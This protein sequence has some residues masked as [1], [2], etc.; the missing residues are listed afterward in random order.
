M[1]IP[2][3]YSKAVLM[4]ITNSYPKPV[5]IKSKKMILSM[6]SMYFAYDASNYIF[7]DQTTGVIWS[8]LRILFLHFS[9]TCYLVPIICLV[10]LVVQTNFIFVQLALLWY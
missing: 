5:T 7:I 2:N 9:R 4:N 3:S 8:V 10:S 6:P 1:I